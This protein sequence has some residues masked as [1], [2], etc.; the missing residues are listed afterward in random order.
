MVKL[1]GVVSVPFLSRWISGRLLAEQQDD[2]PHGCEDDERG[3]RKCGRRKEV[4]ATRDGPTGSVG[5]M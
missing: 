5:D 4:W 3:K 1:D 2:E